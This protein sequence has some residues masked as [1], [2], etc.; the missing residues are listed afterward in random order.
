MQKLECHME[1]SHALSHEVSTFIYI[2]MCV[3]VCVCVCVYVCMYK[4]RPHDHEN[5]LICVVFIYCIP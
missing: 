2:Y 3:C 1:G 5:Q 4:Q